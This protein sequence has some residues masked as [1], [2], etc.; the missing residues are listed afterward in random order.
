MVV[1]GNKLWKLASFLVLGLALLV[2]ACASQGAKTSSENLLT[3]NAPAPE[4]IIGPGDTLQIFVWRNKDLSTVIPVRPDGRISIPLVEDIQ[5]AGK[6]P[7]ELARV[8]ENKLKVF[9]QNPVVTVSV[10]NFVGAYSQQVRVIGEAAHPQAIPYRDNMTLLDVMI[11]VGG[12]TQ[13]AAGNRA[14]VVRTVDGKQKVIPVDVASLV[15]DGDLSA[16]IR[17]EPGDVLVIPE[18]WF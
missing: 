1:G 13:F 8:I 5:A 9:V 18:S 12:L 14:E 11:Q 7:T 10:L 17:M 3:S 2:T 15:K 16:N 6:T 4:Y